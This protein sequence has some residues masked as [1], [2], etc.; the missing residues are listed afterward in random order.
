MQVTCQ[1]RGYVPEMHIQQIQFMHAGRLFP[2]H[3]DP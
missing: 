2:L 3:S 1:A